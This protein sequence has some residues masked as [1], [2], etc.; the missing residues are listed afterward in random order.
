MASKLVRSFFLRSEN[1]YLYYKLRVPDNYSYQLEQLKNF[2]K[3]LHYVHK[4]KTYTAEKRLNQGI[5]SYAIVFDIVIE[6]SS[7]DLYLAFSSQFETYIQ[8]ALEFYLPS[9]TYQVAPNPFAG[10]P[11]EWNDSKKVQGYECVAGT[12]LGYTLSNVFYS[13]RIDKFEP[14]NFPINGII[15]NIQQ[16]L[17]DQKVF[18]Q[19]VLSF[20]NRVNTKSIKAELNE[21]RQ[22]NYERFSLRNTKP[23]VKTEITNLLLPDDEKV[24]LNNMDQRVS[25]QT[26]FISANIKAVALC[27]AQLYIE[28]ENL[29]EQALR[30]NS[31][32]TRQDINEIEK[33]HLTSTNQRYFN[34]SGLKSPSGVPFLH[35]TFYFPP[36]WLEPF[37]ANLYDN[38]YYYNENRYRRQVIYRR[39]L[40]RSTQAPWYNKNTLL[41]FDTVTSVFQI[42]TIK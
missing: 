15:R 16:N 10:M 26:E 34:L 35:S 12:A 25:V 28:T 22:K 38:L 6:K 1:N 24:R 21:F 42:P 33:I 29:L 8:K 30:S 9:I 5:A 23:Q 31:K 41:D 36:T 19:Y 17:K 40:K 2:F 11:K 20:E 3:Y 18:L 4:F 32:K 27:S 37:V 7:V 39:L 14:Q 13:Q